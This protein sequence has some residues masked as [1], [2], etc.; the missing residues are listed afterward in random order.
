LAL[1]RLGS[2]LRPAG[3]SG[4]ALPFA[5]LAMFVLSAMVSTVA[6]F[7]LSNLGGTHRDASRSNAYDLAESGLNEAISVLMETSDPTSQSGFPQS[8]QPA[9]PQIT[10]AQGTASYWGVFDGGTNV[11][12]LYGLG[13]ARNTAA[14][15]GT[16]QAEV[17]QQVDVVPGEST[18]DL[19]SWDGLFAELPGGGCMTLSGGITVT[20]PAY[21]NGNLCISGGTHFTGPTLQ[22]TGNLTMSGGS[23]IGA[24]AAPIQRLSVSGATSIVGGSHVYATAQDHITDT[25]TEPPVDIANWY[26]N[27]DIGPKTTCTTQSGSVPAFDNDSTQNWSLGST[28]LTPGGKPYSCVTEDAQGNVI[29]QLTWNGAWSNGTLAVK[30]VIFFDGPIYMTSVGT[31]TYTGQA[32]IY[33]AT[34][35]VSGGAQLCGIA[36]CTSSW[37]PSQ[38]LI[39][40]VAG[41][42][43]VTGYSLSGGGTVQAAVYCVGNASISGGGTSWG[44][45]T[46]DN[47][48]ISGGAI[49]PTAINQMP[50]GAPVNSISS[51]PTLS[52]DQGSFT[53]NP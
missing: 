40:F 37:D 14:G 3:E 20:D 13:V 12:T 47:I 41:K 19:T 34:V 26:A 8:S 24:S 44:P 39:V 18:Q 31:V 48:S 5:L 15:D 29:G 16:A 23:Y 50:K 21:V 4:I 6:Y 17:S 32:T 9:S 2:R 52:V 45:I 7:T 36:G 49:L 42:P 25:V 51:S 30:G 35:T 43:N 38:N 46:A 33:A 10:T 22:V 28:N 11:W 1:T 27:A 53:Q